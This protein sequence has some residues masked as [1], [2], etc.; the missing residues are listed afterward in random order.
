MI[1]HLYFDAATRGQNGPSAAGVIIVAAHSQTPF[2]TT[3]ADMSNHAAEFAAASFALNCVA[4]LAEPTDT[5]MLHSD[6][7]IVIDSLTKGY[8]KNFMADVTHINQQLDQYRNVILE[9]IPE[10]Q[11]QGAHQLANQALATI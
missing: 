1:Y 7:K 4:P 9:W 11:N 10:K 8:A 5:L 6:S 2:K 3:L